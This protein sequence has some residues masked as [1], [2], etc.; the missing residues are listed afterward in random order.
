M[1][2]RLERPFY[3]L[4]RRIVSI[5]V[6]ALFRPLKHAEGGDGRCNGLCRLYDIVEYVAGGSAASELEG[7]LGHEAGVDGG[8]KSGDSWVSACDS[9]SREAAT[10][11]TWVG[12]WRKCCTGLSMYNIEC[13]V[14]YHVS[15]A[16]FE[17]WAS[18]CSQ[19]TGGRGYSMLEWCCRSC[20]SVRSR[21]ASR[22]T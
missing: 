17:A 12:V 8:T 22:R 4:V 9:E 11:A 14:A 16:E 3:L 21:S 5:E 6:D 10:A 1:Q 13:R 20:S 19:D 7:I 18:C 15:G 2:W